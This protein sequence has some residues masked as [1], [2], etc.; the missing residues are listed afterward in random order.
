M[1]GLNPTIGDWSRRQNGQLDQSIINLKPKPIGVVTAHLGQRL[2]IKT[3]QNGIE[4]SVDALT[5]APHSCESR[6]RNNRSNQ[7]VLNRSYSSRIIKNITDKSR[8]K[9]IFI[10]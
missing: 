10:L 4:H 1:K 5:N 3:N 2:A 8:N 7:S 6:N 9:H